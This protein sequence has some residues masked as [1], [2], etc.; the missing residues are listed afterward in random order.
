MGKL[1]AG[2]VHVYTGNG[3]GKTTAALGLAL[4][5]SGSGL[6][7]FVQQFAKAKDCGE[8]KALARLRNIKVSQCGNVSFIIGKP[9]ITD[10]QCARRGLE[11]AVESILSGKYDLVILDEINVAM[12]LGLIDSSEVKE[13]IAAKPACV[14]LVLTGRGCPVSI[15]KIADLVTEMREVR[16]PY[17]KGI[18]ARQGIEY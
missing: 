3:K 2:F 16:H 18:A 1:C 4:R 14:E 13:L 5:A 6:K 12:N 15:K 10:I 8:L 9:K 7:V 11:L 17:K